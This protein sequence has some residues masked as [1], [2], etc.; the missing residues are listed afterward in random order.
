MPE[1]PDPIADDTLVV[2]QEVKKAAA[3]ESKLLAHY[4]S[5]GKAVQPRDIRHYEGDYIFCLSFWDINELI[6]IEPSRG[7]MYIYSSSEAFDEE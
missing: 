4:K 1:I 5:K 3:R 7:G 2:Y 6:D